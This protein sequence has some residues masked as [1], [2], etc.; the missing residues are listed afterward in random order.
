MAME[1]VI[2]AIRFN[3][4]TYIDFHKWVTNLKRFEEYKEAKFVVS[5][6]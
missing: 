2:E 1:R 3:K 4:T 6:E 5:H